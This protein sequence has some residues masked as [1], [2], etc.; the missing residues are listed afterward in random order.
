MARPC[1]PPDRRDAQDLAAAVIM[2]PADLKIEDQ[3]LW[4]G[5]EMQTQDFEK[6][7]A[8]CSACHTR[9]GVAGMSRWRMP[10]P[11]SA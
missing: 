8:S 9:I 5:N 4:P 1:T 2:D 6:Y 3:T 11:W 7:P 10:A